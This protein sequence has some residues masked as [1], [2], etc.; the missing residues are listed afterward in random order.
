MAG[1]AQ[2]TRP[3]FSV[4]PELCC[5]ACPGAMDTWIFTT[6]TV[7]LK[8][9]ERLSFLMPVYPQTHEVWP[10]LPMDF[11]LVKE[12][13]QTSFWCNAVTIPLHLLKQN[14]L[15]IIAQVLLVEN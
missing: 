7:F 15:E 2:E 9:L 11:Y 6:E 1:S 14:G 5:L 10:Q 3:P 12:G 4:P 8:H 13:S